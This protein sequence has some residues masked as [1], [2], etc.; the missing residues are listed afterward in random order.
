MTQEERLKLKEWQEY[1]K[2]IANA[3]PV[4]TGLS[5]AEIARKKAKLEKDPIAWI[6]YFFPSYAKYE[7]AP[8]HVK[9]IKRM[10]NNDEWF[11]VLSWSRELAKSTV[12]M[13]VVLYRVL[14]GRNRNVILAAATQ[15]AAERLL[16]P[17]KANLEANG[18]IKAFYGEQENQGQ[19]TGCE[20][21]LKNGA[22]FLG[23][24]AGNAPRGSRAEA[25]RP[26]TT[27]FFYYP[28]INVESL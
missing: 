7:F 8:F 2:D 18:R 5:E 26:D 16:R 9:A 13:F 12:V 25:V 10:I 19:W 3:T 17:Y 22:S 27:L 21:V 23:I 28:G 14:T 15:D 1:K 4:E 24:G 20:F 6:H 11:E